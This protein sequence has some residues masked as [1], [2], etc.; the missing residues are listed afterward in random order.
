MAISRSKT[1]GKLITILLVILLLA[2]LLMIPFQ[3]PGNVGAG[4]F[5]P[6]W[7]ASYLLAHGQD[8]SDPKQMYHIE[9]TLTGWNN[10][11]T[12]YAWFAPTGNLVLLP[13]TF[14]PFS[15]ATFYWLF[16][17]IFIIFLSIILI[18]RNKNTHLWIPLITAFSFSMTLVS[19]AIGQVN[20]LEL[21]GLA[22]FLAFNEARYDFFAGAS[23]V[24]TTVKP[25]LV[26]I[27]LPLLLLDF[28]RK[29]QWRVLSGFLISLLI[30]I[31]ILSVIY[32]AWPISFWKLLTYGMGT[33]RETPTLNGLLVVTGEYI[34]GKW[35]WLAIL[36][37]AIIIW[38]KYGGG[39]DRRTLIDVTI[40]TGL[41]ISPI[42]WSYDQVMLLFPL[43]RIFEWMVNGTLKNTDTTIIFM[44]LL[45]FNA[46]SFYQRTLEV[47]DVWFF[48][49]PIVTAIAYIYAW[50]RKK[51]TMDLNMMGTG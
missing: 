25:H 32:P 38:W 33:I 29:K 1:R 42:G 20:T 41:V 51:V 11:F 47:S 22:L 16:T 43:L 45:A 40:V 24:L 3:L 48:W 34:W 23:L 21:L 5:R 10:P 36:G 6:Y 37:V 7:S 27:T 28:I 35:I 12:M 8:F 39:W 14:L 15:R 4:D 19:L 50:Q 17:N 26:I 18:W 9:R 2:I 49:V 46:F 31:F 30:C 13:F 44:I